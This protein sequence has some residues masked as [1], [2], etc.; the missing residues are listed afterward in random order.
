MRRSFLINL[1]MQEIEQGTV[2]WLTFPQIWEKMVHWV[3]SISAEWN[4]KNETYRYSWNNKKGRLISR[5]S[6]RWA[7]LKQR[8][9][10]NVKGK[11]NYLIRN[12]SLDRVDATDIKHGRGRKPLEK[13]GERV[14]IDG[15]LKIW[16]RE[17]P[18][19]NWR[20]NDAIVDEIKRDLIRTRISWNI[21]KSKFPF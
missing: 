19:W 10:I 13:P 2:S 15:S 14:V 21:S 17:C 3:T 7:S 12:S 6:L 8:R 11:R 18:A 4:K 16:S 20:L 5:C 1:K 9:C